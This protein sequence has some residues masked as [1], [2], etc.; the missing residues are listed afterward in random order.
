[1]LQV[2][3]VDRLLGRLLDAVD[4]DALLVVTADHGASF[5]TGE[6]RRPANRV[7][8]GA[9]ASVPFFVR[10]PGQRD[11]HVDD[12]AVRTTDVLPTIARAA[13]V[14][15]PWKPDGM[16]AEERAV[17]LEAPIAVSH[18]GEPALTAPLGSVLAQRREREAVEARLL[19]DGVYAIGPRPDLIGRRVDGAEV[20]DARPPFVSGEVEGLAPGTELAVAVDGRV[21]ATTRVYGDGGR[22]LYTALL[23]RTGAVAL[24][25]VRG[26][27]LRPL[28]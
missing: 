13:G 22:S 17:D 6:P 11:G 28:G 3:Y 24:F 14:T 23:P 25:A 1:V 18:A 4:D 9:I 10:L 12:G 2:Q 16:P 19:R 8:V 20:E 15:L 21:A 27:E 5:T 7:N 26:D